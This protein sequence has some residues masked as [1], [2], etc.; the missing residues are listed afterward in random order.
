MWSLEDLKQH[1]RDT[2][3]VSPASTIVQA[4]EQAGFVANTRITAPVQVVYFQ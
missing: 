4:M 3:V 2:A 1:A